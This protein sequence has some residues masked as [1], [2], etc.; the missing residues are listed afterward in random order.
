MATLDDLFDQYLHLIEPP[1]EAVERAANAQGPLREDL[2]KD[3]GYGPFVARTILSGSYGRETATFFIKDVDVII[4]TTFTKGYL[5]QQKRKDETEQGCLLRLTQEA[6]KRTG[7]TAETRKAR[8]S[9]H[10]KLTE[11]V[12]NLGKSMPELT[13]DIVPVLIQTDKDHD[14]MTIADKDLQGW[15]DTY[16]ITQLGDS[17]ERNKRSATI[18]DR[19]GYKPLVKIFKAWKQVHF[20]STKTPKGFVLECLTAKYHNPRAEHWIV[21]VCDLF[22][23]ICNAWPNPENILA[24]PEVPDISNSALH[25]IPIAK[26]VE[27]AQ[28]VMRKIHQH[29]ALVKQAIEEAESDLA[30][31]AKTLQRVFGQD[32][33]GIYFPLPEEDDGGS[34]GRKSSPVVK[35]KS[36]VREAPAFG[37]A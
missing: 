4:Q 26:K 21:A 8:R 24:I 9:I 17:V 23:N 37:H 25:P 31:S 30:K 27:D 28:R 18:G 35:S 14:P 34:G 32:Y 36:D 16:P 13:M 33:D 15:Y 1:P 22:Q 19:N 10:V 7:R 20:S 3:E 11:E 29:L 2:E 6:I 12:N 5:A